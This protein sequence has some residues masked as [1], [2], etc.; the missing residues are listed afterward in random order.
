MRRKI[1]T[2]IPLPAA[3]IAALWASSAGAVHVEKYQVPYFGLAGQYVV[4]DSAR[5]DG[6][7]EG[8]LD[9]DVSATGNTLRFENGT[10]RF[11]F[12]VTSVTPQKLSKD[13]MKLFVPPDG[14]FEIRPLPF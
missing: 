11:R 4:T 9:F 12:E 10:E 1:S 5:K 2:L 7:G 6:H 13:E 8:V 3:A 14:Y